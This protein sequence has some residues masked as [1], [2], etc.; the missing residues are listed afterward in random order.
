M[1]WHILYTT[2]LDLP[3]R[4]ELR[5][6]LNATL[7]CLIDY[8]AALPRPYWIHGFPA[9]RIHHIPS[10]YQKT[11][12]TCVYCS[13]DSRSIFVLKGRPNIGLF[14]RIFRFPK[15][16]RP[17]LTILIIWHFVTHLTIPLPE[18]IKMTGYYPS[19][20]IQNQTVSEYKARCSQNLTMNK[21]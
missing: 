11:F 20:P 5:C 12:A 8:T 10:I 19:L 7:P 17:S 15:R 21:H 2:A 16:G 13:S 18:L 9:Y 1:A 14:L 6:V 4:A 3:P